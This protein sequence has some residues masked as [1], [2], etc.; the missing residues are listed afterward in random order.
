[1]PGTLLV[2][3]AP[4]VGVN[5]MIFAVDTTSGA[6][7]TLANAAGISATADPRFQ[8]VSFT[9]SDG[10]TI[11]SYS[12]TLSN[13][14]NNTVAPTIFPDKCRW[15]MATTSTVYCAVPDSDPGTSYLD[16]WHMGTQSLADDIWS[17]NFATGVSTLVAVPGSRQGGQTSD[18]F[19]M[20]ISP[21]E[22][23]LAYTT[24]TARAL[25][26]VLLPQ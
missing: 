2:Q 16:A 21:N 1:S 26:G 10:T 23:Y 17:I 9:V 24:K 15:D 12:H 19:E 20:A 5:G 13:G 25:W 8:K 7:S 4:A 18:I 14:V 11:S 3:T 6:V 22:H